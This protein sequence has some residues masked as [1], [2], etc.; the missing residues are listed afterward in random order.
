MAAPSHTSV[1]PRD[2]M[3]PLVDRWP[4]LGQRRPLVGYLC[5]IVALDLVAIVFSRFPVFFAGQMC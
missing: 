5:G 4:L 1:K 3:T 2:G